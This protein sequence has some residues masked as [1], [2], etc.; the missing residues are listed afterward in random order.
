MSNIAERIKTIVC[1]RLELNADDVS[2][3]SS[4]VEDLGADSLDLVE[5]AMAI[6]ESFALRIKDHDYVHLTRIGDAAAYIE[7][8]M[9][10]SNAQAQ[11]A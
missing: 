9:Q 11:H 10:S 3:D 7:S 1:E 2:L 5:L 8:R 4:F 6:E